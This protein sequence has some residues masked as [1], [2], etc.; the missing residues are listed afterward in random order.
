MNGRQ[1]S[2]EGLFLGM[3][4]DKTSVM[5]YRRL[6]VGSGIH[7]SN[8]GLQTTHDIYINGYFM[9]LFDVTPDRTAL[10]G[11]ASQPDNGNIRVELRIVKALP[12]PV[13]CL[14]YLQF[15]NTISIDKLR[16]V[17]KDF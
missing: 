8:S 5:D 13:T 10:D 1:I 12:G 7:H 11:H 2:A 15:D 14:F 16:T 17:W 3:D 6:F 4:H 9:L